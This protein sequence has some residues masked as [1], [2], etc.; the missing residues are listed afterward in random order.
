[1][2]TAVSRDGKELYV[3]TGRGNAMAIID[4]L[5]ASG[6]SRSIP[7]GQNST[8]QTAHQMTSPV[9]VKSRKE[10]RGIKVGDGPWGI[11]VVNA[12]K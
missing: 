3:S 7:A 11:A 4:T 5:T 6:E 1:M 8:P 9:D 2:G 10:L 12:T